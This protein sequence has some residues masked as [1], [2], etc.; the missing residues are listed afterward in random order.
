MTS[1]PIW[2]HQM[3][4]ANPSIPQP[5]RRPAMRADVKPGTTF[6]DYQLP[7]QTGQPRRLS[8]IQVGDPMIIVLAREA[9]SA[10]DQRQH[11]GLVQ[12]WS[13]MKPGVGYCQMVTITTSDPQETYNYRSGVNAEWPFLSDLRVRA[14][15]E[16]GDTDRF[17]PPELGWPQ[18]VS[19]RPRS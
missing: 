3:A 5:R 17:Y 2:R 14:A 16:G 19:G 11:E 9:Y 15:W 4:H 12:L 18:E 10:K 8:E 13:E 7:D 1:A 6:P